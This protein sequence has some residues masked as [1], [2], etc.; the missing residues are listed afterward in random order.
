MRS[1]G[2]SFRRRA[3]ST[4]R[5]FTMDAQLPP[6]SSRGRF[7]ISI[8]GLIV[9][10][11]CCGVILWS[12]RVVRESSPVRVQIR[13]L[14]TGD[15][16]ERRSAATG[17]ESYTAEDAG[18]VIPALVV[19]LGDE[20]E[21]VRATVARS[22]GRNW[23]VA[24]ALALDHGAWRWMVQALMRTLNDTRPS[25][26]S[27]AAEGLTDIFSIVGNGRP[28][29]VADLVDPT[30][31]VDSL[32]RLLGDESEEVRMSA[33]TSLGAFGAACP[34][35]PPRELVTALVKDSSANTR[36]LAARALGKFPTISDEAAVA[37]LGALKVDELRVRRACG[38]TRREVRRVEQARAGDVRPSEPLV[39]ALVEALASR[40]REVRHD[41]ATLSGKLAHRAESVIPALIDVLKYPDDPKM[42]GSSLAVTAR[43][44]A[45]AAAE[46]LGRIA[47][48]GARAREVVD[49]LAHT[50]RG[51][52]D[53]WLRAV[54]AR[55]VAK[56]SP[57]EAEPAI[58][59]LIAV[60]GETSGVMGPP[61]LRSP[62][63]WD[64]WPRP[65]RSPAKPSDP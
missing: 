35:E 39:P 45:L 20:D 41:A 58:P 15:V 4:D 26:R 21:E 59:V 36:A 56:F 28:G 14:R 27:A 25:V 9:V 18:V 64:G 11:A 7:R 17:L 42:I 33:A 6:A 48:G 47:P 5:G 32:G 44:P 40:D 61:D 8:L 49:A 19:A 1:G 60:L 62:P 22:L 12:W 46:S 65:R 38:D 55:A 23:A 43:D 37:L 50:V 24:R 31:V 29:N 13:M 52:G 30:A 34:I 2:V 10:V 51:Q 16:L 54:A 57:Q 53:G 3:F 63:P